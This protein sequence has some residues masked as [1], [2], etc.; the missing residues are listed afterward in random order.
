MWCKLAHNKNKTQT[1]IVESTKEFYKLL[2]SPRI[3]VCNLIFPHADAA[4]VSCKHFCDN[5]PAGKNV[6][7]AFAA[8][9]TTQSRLKLLGNLKKFGRCVLYSDTGRVI[10]SKGRWNPKVCNKGA[11]CVTSQMSWRSLALAPSYRSLSRSVL[12]FTRFRYF[13]PYR[14]PYN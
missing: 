2:T 7:V 5:V 6:N 8:I 14:L 1:T 11:I 3:E 10:R 13:A 4:W 9:L 12:K